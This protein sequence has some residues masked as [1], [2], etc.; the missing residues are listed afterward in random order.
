MQ[1]YYI[2]YNMEIG[3][4]RMEIGK[5]GKSIKDSE[6]EANHE[7]RNINL[8]SLIDNEMDTE[9]MNLTQIDAWE[10]L[11]QKDFKSTMLEQYD[12]EDEGQFSENG[13]NI[14]EIEFY[15]L[16]EKRGH[17]QG[18]LR[19]NSSKE[20]KKMIK[21]SVPATIPTVPNNQE[22]ESKQ[23]E[24]KEKQS[25]NDTNRN[26]QLQIERKLKKVRRHSSDLE[27]SYI[28]L[29]SQYPI[30]FIYLPQ[31]IIYLFIL[32]YNVLNLKQ[33]IKQFVYLNQLQLSNVKQF[34]F[35]LNFTLLIM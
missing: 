2:T 15:L 7:P 16:N 21:S 18:K 17:E 31:V 29:Y 8:W 19:A 33:N 30:K 28:S 5:S 23:Q 12:E 20:V 11:V 22:I 14:T 9:M 13:R 1:R 32:H 3:Y 26:H 6:A 35:I 4:M 25:R 34:F 27:L 24:E 10:D